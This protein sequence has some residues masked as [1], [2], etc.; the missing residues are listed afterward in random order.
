MEDIKKD[1]L[2]KMEVAS[3]S[4]NTLKEREEK[5]INFF[6][7]KKDWI[8]YLVL[9]FIVW[10]SMYIRTRNLPLLKDVTTGDWTLGPDLDPWLFLRW[11]EYIVENGSLMALDT[12]RYVPVGFYTARELPLL[13]HMIAW[14]H[15]ILS[16]FSISNSVTYSA[17]L[18]PVFMAG[19]TAIAFFLFSRKIF[20]KEKKIV[21]N[22]I[23]LIATSFF[24]LTPSLL[25]R[26]IAGIPEKESA[27]FFFMFMAFYLFLEAFT[28]KK[29]KSQLIFGSLSGIATGLMALTW[30]GVVFVFFTIP[31][32]ILLSFIFKKI[33]KRELMVYGSWLTFTFGSILP[34]TEKYSLQSIFYSIYTL[35]G[36]GVF[37][38]ILLSFILNKSERL[39]VIRKKTKLPKQI[40]LLIVSSLI[41]IVLI[42]IILGPSL[43]T[44]QLTG[45]KNSLITPM[46]TRFGL[47]VAENKQPFFINDWKGSFG[48]IVSNIPLYFW[49]FF[50]GSVFMFKSLISKLNKRERIILTFSYFIFLVCLIFSRYSNESILNGTSG[51][52]LLM[53]FG[54]VA[55]FLGCF[56]YVYYKR[57]KNSELLIF[58]EFNFS[59][60]LYFVILTIGI[61][62]ARGGIRLIMV[63]GAISPIAVSFF[64]VKIFMNFFKEKEESRRFFSLILVLLI[65]IASVFTLWTY[66]QSDKAVA[67]GFAPSSYNHQWQKAMSWVRENTS[68]TAVFGH[69][70]DY[71]YWVQGIGKRATIL[72]GSNSIIYWNH[73]MGRYVLT[74][75]S[76]KDAAEFLY[77]HNGTHLLID[78]TEIGKYTAYSSIGADENY[79]RFSWI[80]TF[81]ID[82]SQTQETK[83]EVIYVYR[84]GTNTDED[85]VWKN[86]GREIFLPGGKTVLG[87]FIVKIDAKDKFLQPEAI[88]IYQNKQYLIPLKYA[89][90]ENNLREFDS[91]LDA[92]VFVYPS[93][94]QREGGIS[95]NKIGALLYLSPRTIHSQIANL[96]LFNQDSDYFK[97]VHE[98]SNLIVEQLRQQGQ[99]IGEF[100]HYQGFQGP[101]KIWEV[102]YPKDIEFKKEYLEK[103]YP[104]NNLSL[105]KSGVY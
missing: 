67:S 75:T 53:Y 11:A 36:I 105:A 44:K 14:F 34:F 77:A 87:G 29:F 88:F 54:G 63:L 5:I 9:A 99:I 74:G 38:I 69:W 35:A 52:S 64:N 1:L 91:G 57:Y 61:I 80:S 49:L 56:G 16:T 13:H 66:Y 82:E 40:F 73:L 48:P 85:I 23:A 33:G 31:F 10:L 68:P 22:V 81:T 15:N 65:V 89:Y 18:F 76:D 98:E 71:G 12:M 7:Q 2:G 3:L 60:I 4:R 45:V 55:F 24:I 39:E 46:T 96:Y 20:Y 92:G 21:R 58:K 70:W 30:G 84:G 62:G 102:A 42:S 47:T 6:K 72:D 37:V 8:V 83:N 93:M 28:S 25:S 43:L 104:N 17:I 90:S 51:I 19:L 32:A 50:I 103:K 97:L 79:D 101:I 95:I 41:L 100:L 26:T 94:M 27:A 78:S 86:E 59:Y